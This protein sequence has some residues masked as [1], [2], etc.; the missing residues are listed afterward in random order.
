MFCKPRTTKAVGF[1][2]YVWPDIGD[3]DSVERLRVKILPE[4]Q[5]ERWTRIVE[6]E[7]AQ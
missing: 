2:K 7:R 3:I 6:L 5:I 1:G 4:P